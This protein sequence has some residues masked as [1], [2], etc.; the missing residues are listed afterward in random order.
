[1]LPIVLSTLV[2][3]IMNLLDQYLYYFILTIKNQ[4][5]ITAT[6]NYGV[7]VGKVIPLHN[8]PASISF[9]IAVATLIAILLPWLK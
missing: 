9:S 4:N 5:N 8:I 1:M 2:T 7:Y 6:I 3:N